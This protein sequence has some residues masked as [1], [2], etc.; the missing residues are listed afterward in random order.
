[1]SASPGYCGSFGPLGLVGALLGQEGNYDMTQTHLIP[2]AYSYYDELSS[3]ARERL[4]GQLLAGG[5][6]HRES[7]KD[8]KSSGPLPDDW[9]RAGYVSADD[10]VKAVGAA[11]AAAGAALA[12][13]GA[14]AAAGGAAAAAAQALAAIANALAAVA[15]P[16]GA[17]LGAIAGGLVGPALVAG[18]LKDIGETENHIISMLSTRYLTNQ[19]LYQREPNPD[20]DNR[21]NANG[22]P[23]CM[24]LVL[25]ELR[26]I[27]RDDFS[28]YNAKPYQEETRWPILNLATYAYDHEV[29]LA[30]R[31]ALDYV[32]AHIAAS[33]PSAAATKTRTLRKLTVTQ[34]SEL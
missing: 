1:M 27:L 30:A 11:S 33:C 25:S 31:M 17:A 20:Y 14:A 18:D 6:V 9:T 13:G 8:M 16:I 23:T 21:R 2:L 24:S 34:R 29:R 12:A 7:E 26:N 28:E 10:L 4:I 22:G 3:N 15:G 5:I 32:S 19:L